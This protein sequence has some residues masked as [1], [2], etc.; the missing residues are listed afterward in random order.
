MVIIGALNAF[1]H[2]R[3]LTSA[4]VA[5][6]RLMALKP[7]IVSIPGTTKAA[8]LIENLAA[9]DLQFT[10]VEWESLDAALAKIT[11]FGDLGTV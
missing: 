7:W 11:I 3:G 10:G 6:A 4:Q 1:G 2:P 8:H 5:L 9:A